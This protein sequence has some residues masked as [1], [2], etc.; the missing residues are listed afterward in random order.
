MEGLILQK[1]LQID[2]NQYKEMVDVL[3]FKLREQAKDFKYIYGVSRGGW[4]IAVHLSNFLE[5]ELLTHLKH[6][7]LKDGLIVV[8]DI[9]DTG[10][11]FIDID[12]QLPRINNK[13]LYASLIKRVTT[14]FYPDV[15]VREI[16]DEWVV[17]PWENINKIDDNVKKFLK[18]RNLDKGVYL[19]YHQNQ[20]EL[21][22]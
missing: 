5:K 18:S 10:K 6:Y 20:V 13:I 16:V 7:N 21:N 9:T 3:T 22:F 1:N 15:Y 17:F 19:G 12:S 11:T 8:D 4:P 2:Y 14:N